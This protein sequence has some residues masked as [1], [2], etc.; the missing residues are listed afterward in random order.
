MKQPTRPAG[1]SPYALTYASTHK[2]SVGAL[3]SSPAFCQQQVARF[4]AT[5]A[6]DSGQA[7]RRLERGDDDVKQESRHAPVA[8]R[9]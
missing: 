8:D 6:L 3:I 1:Q 5:S 4:R 7:E 9:A 2:A